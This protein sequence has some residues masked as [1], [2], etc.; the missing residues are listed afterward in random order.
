MIFVD[1]GAW[2]ALA[3]PS[4]PD[5]EAAKTFLSAVTEPLLTSEY[6]VDEL[7]TL[8]AVR[9]QKSKGVEWMHEVLDR[10]GTHL[11]KVGDDDFV[12]ALQIY[13]QFTDKQWS[14]TDCTSYVLMQRL[15]VKKAFSFDQHFHQFGTVTV[16]PASTHNP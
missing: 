4:D 12:K 1:T 13:K 15:N 16:V 8:F 9:G 2:Y 7:L 6:I 10:G 5:H 11:V 3:T 14:F